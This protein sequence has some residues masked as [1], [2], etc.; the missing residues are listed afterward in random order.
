MRECGVR[1]RKDIWRKPLF[2]G[3]FLLYFVCEDKIC[4]KLF[5]TGG[6]EFVFALRCYTAYWSRLG[7]FY[8]SI[9]RDIN[10]LGA[11]IKELIFYEKGVF[12]EK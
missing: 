4:F 6:D 8:S 9:K 1:K 2:I 5:R 3:L 11:N 7:P 12:N 10:N